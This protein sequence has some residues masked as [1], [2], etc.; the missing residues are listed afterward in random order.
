MI[1]SVSSNLY[2]HDPVRGMFMLL[3]TFFAI[4]SVVSHF[5]IIA[6]AEFGAEADERSIDFVKWARSRSSSVF[7]LGPIYD[8][9]D[10]QDVKTNHSMDKFN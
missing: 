4:F 1:C 5:R 3:T 10:F 6:C 2:A 9:N 7:E 8:L